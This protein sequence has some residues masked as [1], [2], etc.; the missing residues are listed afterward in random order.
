V[1]DGRHE[2]EEAPGHRGVRRES[3]PFRPDRL[4]RDLDDDLLPFLDELLDFRLG[5]FFPLA[6]AAAA[7]SIPTGGHGGPRRRVPVGHGRG[8][9]RIVFV[10]LEA[11]EL[12][13]R[14]YDIGDV[15]ETVALETEVNE[16]RLHAGQHFRDPAFVEIASDTALML[17]FDEDFGNL[18]VLE[19]RDPCFVGARGDDH[20]LGHARCSRRA[21]PRTPDGSPLPARAGASAR[22]TAARSLHGPHRDGP[23]RPV[24]SN[25]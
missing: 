7:R 6:A 5:A 2:H 9:G 10:R 8:G 15:E 1:V 21:R 22:S 25:S 20:L 18:I 23:S 24:L 14:R 12:L 11:V 3:R 19:D 13:E 16:R 17:A 4:L